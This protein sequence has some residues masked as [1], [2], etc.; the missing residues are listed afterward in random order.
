M[1]AVDLTDP[2]DVDRLRNAAEQG[3]LA[4]EALQAAELASRERRTVELAQA[5]A[6]WDA[7]L[8]ARAPGEDGDLAGQRTEA[9]AELDA[10]AYAADMDRA[11]E[12]WRRSRTARLTQRQL[13]DAWAQAH[14]RCG[15]GR[16]PPEPSLRQA[17]DDEAHTFARDLDRALER[18]AQVDA[19]AALADLVGDRPSALP[20]ELLPGPEATLKHAPACS[21]P[22]RTEVSQVPAGSHSMG[23]TIR[24]L[25]CSA[26][27]ALHIP[28]P[29]PE[30]IEA[31][32]RGKGLPDVRLPAQGERPGQGG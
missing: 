20:A 9:Q 5:Q 18:A 4:A 10:A 28:A 3:R 25:S 30:E 2:L 14:A 31:A 22:T 13:R 23:T 26:S 15:L 1:T 16:T 7:D 29:E 12:A 11:L 32:Q 8:C 21:D 17:E 27:R 24:C 6:D 19:E